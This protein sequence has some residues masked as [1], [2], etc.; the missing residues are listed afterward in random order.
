MESAGRG[1]G[2]LVDC[3]QSKK[4]NDTKFLKALAEKY[5]QKQLIKT[6]AHNIK[7]NGI[8][9]KENVPN[10]YVSNKRNKLR[11]RKLISNIHTM[12]NSDMS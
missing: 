5:L 7:E 9:D 12:N 6:I 1:R 4:E 8:I 11:I 2:I 10:F 3:K